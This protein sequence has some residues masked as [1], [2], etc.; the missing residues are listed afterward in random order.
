MGNLGGGEIL[1]ILLIGL[2]V[3]GP[4]RLPEASKQIGKTIKQVRQ[5]SRNFQ[6]ELEAAIEDPSIEEAA[7]QKGEEMLESER[8]KS[9]PENEVEVSSFESEVVEGEDHNYE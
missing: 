7:R 1:V 8:R 4:K 2:I 5:T 9:L 3:L 6:A